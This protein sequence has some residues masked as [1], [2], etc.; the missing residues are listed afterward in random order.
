MVEDK[1]EVGA[2][3]SKIAFRIRTR[4]VEYGDNRRFIEYAVLMFRGQK[5]VGYEE[6][7]RRE[8]LDR[9]SALKMAR[10]R[11]RTLASHRLYVI[12]ITRQNITDGEARN[13]NTCAISQALWDNQERMGFSKYEYNFE[14]SPYAAFMEPRGIVLCEKF[15][16][17]DIHLSADALPDMVSGQRGKVVFNDSM[18]H[19]AMNFDDW[20]DSRYMSL[21]EWR[22]EHGY[23]DGERPYRPC[24]ASF[25]LD[26]DAMKPCKE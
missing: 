26:L 5:L 17:N 22:E 4:T 1:T 7:P 11:I 23:E 18:E 24:P 20:G 15:G 13:C 10:A 16:D 12:N 3:T 8:A 19:W 2:D 21:A 6:G 9:P 25:V 14:V